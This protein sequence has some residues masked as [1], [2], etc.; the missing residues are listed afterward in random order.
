MIQNDGELF[1]K[2]NDKLSGQF[3]RIL[4]NS[5]HGIEN[6]QFGTRITTVSSKANICGL[7]IQYFVTNLTGDFL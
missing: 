2:S 4:C 6:A 3:G 5:L 7:R 1:H